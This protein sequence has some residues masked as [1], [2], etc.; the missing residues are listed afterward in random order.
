MELG[1]PGVRPD[2][3]V[4]EISELGDEVGQDRVAPDPL[5]EIDHF[6]AQAAGVF[7]DR[8]DPRQGGLDVRHVQAEF[9]DEAIRMGKI[10]LDVDHDQRRV[11]GM[12]D[13]LDTVEDSG[14]PAISAHR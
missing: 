11:V 4:V 5:L 7:D 14:M 8:I 10:V 1:A 12:D 2:G 9:G 3:D 13:L 6:H